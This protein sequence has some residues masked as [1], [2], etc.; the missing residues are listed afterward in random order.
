MAVPFPLSV[1][2]RP[3]GRAPVSVMAGAGWPVVV[4]VALK[5]APTIELAVLALV[6]AGATSSVR[7]VV[8]AAGTAVQVESSP[9]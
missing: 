1:K 9:P 8:P 6:M 7:V 5:G 2:V 4:T 3:F